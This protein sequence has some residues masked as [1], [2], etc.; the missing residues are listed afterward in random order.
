M[1]STECTNQYV[2]GTANVTTCEESLYHRLQIR[3]D[4]RREKK[5]WRERKDRMKEKRDDIFAD[6]LNGEIPHRI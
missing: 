1:D 6:I 2:S 3:K 5:V 4:M